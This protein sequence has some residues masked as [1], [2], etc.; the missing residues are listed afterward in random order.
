MVGI[1]HIVGVGIT[2]AVLAASTGT[3]LAGPFDVTRNGT[4]VESPPTQPIVL[5]Q[6][7]DTTA[8]PATATPVVVHI[9][10]ASI[11]FHWGDAGIGAAAAIGIVALLVGVGLLLV[12]RH[13]DGINHT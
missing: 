11:G 4:F 7:R 2:A 5:E 1:R 8:A 10:A 12:Q 13:R 9:T 6:M 3:A